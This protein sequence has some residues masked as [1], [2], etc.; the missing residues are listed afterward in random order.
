MLIISFTLVIVSFTIVTVDGTGTTTI[1][2]EV[3]ILSEYLSEITDSL[4]D[5]ISY[6]CFCINNIAVSCLKTQ[7]T[8]ISNQ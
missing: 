4:L 1:S 8:P 3:D 7:H 2:G 5:W 6:L